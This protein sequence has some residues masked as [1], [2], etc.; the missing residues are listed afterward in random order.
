[1]QDATC[2]N[3]NVQSIER[4][5]RVRESAPDAFLLNASKALEPPFRSKGDLSPGSISGG[6]YLHAVLPQQIDRRTF[7]CLSDIDQYKNP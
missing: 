3:A 1:M 7:G 6:F 2:S 5:L 4:F